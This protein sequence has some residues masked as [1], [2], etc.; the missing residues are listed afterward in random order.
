MRRTRLEREGEALTLRTDDAGTVL[1]D[2]AGMVRARHGTDH[3]ETLLD[4]LRREGWRV[5]EDGHVALA[6][7]A[8]RLAG[9]V[10][11]ERGG[12]AATVTDGEDG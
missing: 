2:A 9:P 10:T 6:G 8:P 4:G 7:T 3:H 12:P 1:T 11:A 5:A